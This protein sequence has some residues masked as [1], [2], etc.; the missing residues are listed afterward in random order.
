[1]TGARR[2]ARAWWRWLPLGAGAVGWVG[3][4]L[5]A[6]DRLEASA[7]TGAAAIDDPPR[8]IARAR[9]AGITRLCVFVNDRSQA[10]GPFGTYDKASVLACA[11]EI[12][13]AGIKLTLVSWMTPRP[14]WVG[15][16]ARELG[17][18]A[19]ACGA[20]EL[21]LDLEEP[22]TVV[23]S[24]SD[25]EISAVT[26]ELF[27]S[28]RS[29]F[30]GRLLVDFIVLIEQRVMAPAI[31]LADAAVPQAYDAGDNFIDG[32][33][34]AIAVQRWG[35]LGK[36]LVMGVGAFSK[37]GGVVVGAR[38]LSEYQAALEAVKAL[39]IRRVRI[40]RLEMLD[41]PLVAATL[42]WSGA[43]KAVA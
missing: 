31:R 40:W 38:P 4:A 18:L 25:A 5:L 13:A 42:S 10:N 14:D 11:R 12:R 34:E 24:R 33:L 23:R 26:A 36:P 30:R 9:A 32:E 39:S 35:H 29:S 43:A 41:A 7:W 17:E 3:A 20:D 19:T 37:R 27:R 15:S 22:W 21:E 6:G 1:M 16:G 2:R 8:A 28:L